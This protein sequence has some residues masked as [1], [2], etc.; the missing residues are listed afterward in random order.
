MPFLAVLSKPSSGSGLDMEHQYRIAHVGTG[1]TGSIALR[2]I[3]RSPQL[4]LVGQLVHS[5]DKVGR[6]SGK[7]YSTFMRQ[8]PTGATGFIIAVIVFA[9]SGLLARPTPEQPTNPV[10]E[11]IPVR[12][13]DL[14]PKPGSPEECTTR[15][16]V[17]IGGTLTTPT[18]AIE[19][20]GPCPAETVFGGQPDLV[21][22]PQ[23]PGGG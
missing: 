20:A 8:F 15:N 23:E 14:S 21:V 12:V 16:G 3:L 6:D 10:T 18:V 19:R 4:K 5:R 17:A 22:I 7:S 11:P 9:A 1:Y 13:I 2:Q